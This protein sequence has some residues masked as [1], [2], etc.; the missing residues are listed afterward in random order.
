M[1]VKKL[2]WVR[3]MPL[4]SATVNIISSSWIQDKWLLHIGYGAKNWIYLWHLFTRQKVIQILE[5]L[6]FKFG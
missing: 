2:I 3:H 6:T 5:F 1:T 4:S